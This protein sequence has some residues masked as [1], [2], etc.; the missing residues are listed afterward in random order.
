MHGLR[1]HCTGKKLPNPRKASTGAAYSGFLLRV[2]TLPVQN[3]C[4]A[5]VGA[6]LHHIVSAMLFEH[7]AGLTRYICT[8]H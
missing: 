3:P 4:E 2:K 7:V 8:A 1:V 6:G 5:S